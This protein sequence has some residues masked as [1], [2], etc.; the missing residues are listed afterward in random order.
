MYATIDSTVHVYAPKGNELDAHLA[1]ING[2]NSRADNPTA[3]K[4]NIY[5]GEGYLE[6]MIAE[7]KGNVVV[8]AGIIN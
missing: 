5:T 3:W 7:K 2:Y 8:L 6:R 1:L 4:E